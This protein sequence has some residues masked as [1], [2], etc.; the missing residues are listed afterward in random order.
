MRELVFC[1][2]VF[3]IVFAI[4]VGIGIHKI[5]KAM[6]KDNCHDDTF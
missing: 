4:A 6:T 2:V 5:I 3:G 1:L